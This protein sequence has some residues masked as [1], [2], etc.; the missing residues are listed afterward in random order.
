MFTTDKVTLGYLPTYLGLASEL[1]T[2]ARVCEVGVLDGESLSMWQA[3]FP[4]GLIVGVDRNPNARWPAGT[5][6]VVAAQDEPA[7]PEAVAAYGPFDLIVDDASHDGALTRR[8]W[9]LLWPLVAPGR[10]YVIEDW[11]VAFWQGR[12]ESMLRMA[13]SLLPSLNGGGADSI[14]YRHGQIILRKKDDN[15]R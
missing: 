6:R 5:V 11:Q 8:T 3:L 2:S 12:D 13:E 10:Y 15:A 7:L 14:A 4:E 9:E 1:G